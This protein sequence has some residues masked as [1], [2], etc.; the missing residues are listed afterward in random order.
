MTICETTLCKTTQKYRRRSQSSGLH[1]KSG[2][3]QARNHNMRPLCSLCIVWQSYACLAR[4][5]PLRLEPQ[6]RM[7]LEACGLG[8]WKSICKA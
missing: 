6:S 8:A 5:V 7:Q 2:K 3:Y 4:G 1:F